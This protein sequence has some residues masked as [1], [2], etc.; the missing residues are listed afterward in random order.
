MIFHHVR[1]AAIAESMADCALSG[2]NIL[3]FEPLSDRLQRA[4]FVR[5]S[6]M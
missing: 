4:K 2:E 1:L 3:V 6:E 5:L